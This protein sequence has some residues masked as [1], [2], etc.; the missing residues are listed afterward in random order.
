MRWLFLTLM[1]MS[2]TLGANE[3]ALQVNG[4]LGARFDATLSDENENIYQYG[5]G[6]QAM[7]GIGVYYH[8]CYVGYQFAHA[9]NTIDAFGTSDVRVSASG[10]FTTRY[11]LAEVSYDV[12]NKTRFVT[13]LGLN[14]G[15]AKHA[16]D[17]LRATSSQTG[18]SSTA[19]SEFAYGA[20][21]GIG[22]ALERS[23]L[24]AFQYRFLGSDGFTL[25]NT[26]FDRMQSNTLLFNASYRLFF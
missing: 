19:A 11:H 5:D 6:I 12:R 9:M 3:L 8:Q 10:A 15:V 7:A 22:Y 21:I 16:F 23:L 17:S 20:F 25:Q 4:A 18:F 14:V 26:S 13:T 24:L 1:G 2:M